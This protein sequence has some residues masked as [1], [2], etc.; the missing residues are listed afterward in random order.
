MA[1]I[2]AT[3]VEDQKK[4]LTI[5]VRNEIVRDL[6]TQM[7]AFQP[8]PDR[9]FCGTVAKELVKKFPF[10]KDSGTSVTGYVSLNGNI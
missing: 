1:C 5:S 8:K 10:M 2:E 9:V 4:L 7:F 6:V 3:S